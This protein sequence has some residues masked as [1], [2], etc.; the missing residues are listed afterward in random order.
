VNLEQEL[1][2]ALTRQQAPPGIAERVMARIDSRARPAAAPGLWPWSGFRLAMGFVLLVMIGFSA[3]RQDEV[4]RERQQSEIAARQL[5]TAL[6][7]ASEALND[8]KRIVRQ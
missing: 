6:Q 2:N 8:A 7:I 4:R 5:M 1:T 3:V